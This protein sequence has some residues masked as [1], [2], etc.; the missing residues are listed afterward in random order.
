MDDMV[1]DC[2]DLKVK[3]ESCIA[4]WYA[5][6]LTERTLLNGM[7]GCEKDFKDYRDCVSIGMK[8]FLQRKKAASDVG[9]PGKPK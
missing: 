2:K 3:Y 7:G 6:K 9:A 4:A 8:V 5:D 1:P